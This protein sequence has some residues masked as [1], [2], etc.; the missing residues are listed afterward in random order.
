M[1]RFEPGFSLRGPIPDWLALAVV[2]AS[3]LLAILTVSLMALR[4]R[5]AADEEPGRAPSRVRDPV[6]LL[7]AACVVVLAVAAWLLR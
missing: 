5:P 3:M 1:T 6:L 7:S 2:I 4:L